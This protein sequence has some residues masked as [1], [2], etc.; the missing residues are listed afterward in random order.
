MLHDVDL[1]AV[2]P[3]HVVEIMAEHP[4]RGPDPTARSQTH[5]NFNEAIREC[6]APLADQS[7]RREGA[8]CA[9]PRIGTP[10][11]DREVAVTVE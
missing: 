2:R 1:A 7:R 6:H 8:A 11:S 3:T 10:H 5:A 4:D 9:Q